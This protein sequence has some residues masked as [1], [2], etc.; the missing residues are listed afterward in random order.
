MSKNDGSEAKLDSFFTQEYAIKPI[1]KL[2]SNQNKS[3]RKK[4]IETLGGFGI[5]SSIIIP[6]LEKL[7]QN[8]PEH[9]DEIQKTIIKIKNNDI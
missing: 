8:N 6:E 4:T 5:G 7:M 3:V 1:A 9:K 2:L